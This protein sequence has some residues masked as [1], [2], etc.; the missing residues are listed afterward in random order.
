ML[1]V[2]CGALRR[3]QSIHGLDG[4]TAPRHLLP[5]PLPLLRRD[6]LALEQHVRGGDGGVVGNDGMTVPAKPLAGPW[7]AAVDFCPAGVRLPARGGALPARG[8]A[9]AAR[10]PRR[11]SRAHGGR[12]AG[13]ACDN[14]I[15]CQCGVSGPA[16][17]HRQG[18]SPG[19]ATSR[20][21]CCCSGKAPCTAAQRHGGFVNTRCVQLQPPRPALP[22]HLQAHHHIWRAC[23]PAGLQAARLGA[24]RPAAPR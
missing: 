15:V 1:T 20:A 13:D 7:A 18:G 21:G 23:P 6:D 24:G 17:W 14:S 16:L 10:G 2:V 19:T 8:G 22:V 5:E 12:L 3:R 4:Q 11:A 9:L